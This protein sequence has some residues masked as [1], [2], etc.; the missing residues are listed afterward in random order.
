VGQKQGKGH[1]IPVYMEKDPCRRCHREKRSD[2]AIQKPRKGAEGAIAF[3]SGGAAS[4]EE[5]ATVAS[6]YA[7]F[8]LAAASLAL[9]LT[10]LAP[11]SASADEGVRVMTWNLYL[12]TNF[13]ELIS[14]TTFEG[15]KAAVT[16]TYNNILATKPN[17]RA[18][19]VA[20]EIAKNRPDVVSLQEV[21]AL[22][23]QGY[24]KV[25][26]QNVRSQKRS[27]CP[28]ITASREAQPCGIVIGPMAVGMVKRRSN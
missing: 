20:R 10:L 26:Y 13:Q 24:Q 3:L 7:Q 22:G 23:S 16:A 15:F 14:A 21:L 8:R 4:T 6:L 2:E 1:V 5:S 9:A 17:E 11:V 28:L 25:R 19:A 18:A 12:G 27:G